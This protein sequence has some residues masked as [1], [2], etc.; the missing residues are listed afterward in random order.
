MIDFWENNF[1]AGNIKWGKEPA[2]SAI[3]ANKIFLT[4]KIK[5]ILI[6]GIGY[7]RN[8]LNFFGKRY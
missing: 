5:N 6:P 4:N 8:A 3:I 2:D 1:K 7:G